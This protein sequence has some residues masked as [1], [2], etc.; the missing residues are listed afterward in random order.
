MGLYKQGLFYRNDSLDAFIQIGDKNFE[1]TKA[2]IKSIT[3]DA[4]KNL[5]GVSSQGIFRYDPHKDELYI[6]GDRF[7]TFDVGAYMYEPSFS[8]SAGELLFG[9]PGGYYKC[10]PNKV[11]NAASPQIV[12]TDFKINGRSIKS[13]NE[14]PL[15]GALED[16][17]EIT[18]HYNQ[19][20]ISIDFA[21]IH[22]ADP[23]NNI[24]QY[25]LEGYE[26]EWRDVRE[27]K[28]AYY[29]NI[30][31]GHYVFKV[32]A[33]SSYGVNAEK[34]IRIIVLPPWWQTWWA[35]T[36]YAI[37]LVS[38]VWAFIKWRTK[39]L[40]KEKDVLEK[41]VNDR[42]KELKKEKE[43]VEKTL[44]ELKATQSQLIQ[45]EKMAS[46]GELTAGIAHEIQNPLNFVNNFS[47]V[48]S[49]LIDELKSELAVKAIRNRQLK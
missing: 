10:L 46:L 2:R 40:K 11:Y 3:E 41:K 45:S 9:N 29:F 13:G 33:T 31:P 16:A 18:L 17:K 8:T 28:A 4:N 22:F 39:A 36:L 32:R 49:E 48:N 43:L 7:G 24:H 21:G 27:E 44:S 37:L 19:N 1:F 47:E 15:K 23:E 26:N 14:T 12:I 20:K 34:S 38:A 5:W 30:P 6:F 25:M 35:Y 42:T